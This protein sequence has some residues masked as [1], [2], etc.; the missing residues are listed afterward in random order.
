M[1]KKFVVI[2]VFAIFA[3]SVLAISTIG[4]LPEYSVDYITLNHLEIIKYDA[5][6][7]DGDKIIYVNETIFNAG[8]SVDIPLMIDPETD[9]TYN[10]LVIPMVSGDLQ[11]GVFTSVD[12]LTMSIFVAYS[13]IRLINNK[14][15]ITVKVY[16]TYSRLED[17]VILLFQ[18]SGDV[19]DDD[20]D[21]M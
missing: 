1:E 18:R 16:D 19:I 12:I 21:A 3:L 20:P 8:D 10:L 14:I 17:E 15:S 4:N 9:A 13:D 7:L 6:N 2:L 5:K 11:R